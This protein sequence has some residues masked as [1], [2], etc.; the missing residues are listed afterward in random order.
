[1]LDPVTAAGE[2]A[3]ATAR[4][5]YKDVRNATVRISETGEDPVR[6]LATWASAG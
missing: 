5:L 6:V 1:L 4:D 2:P 3:G